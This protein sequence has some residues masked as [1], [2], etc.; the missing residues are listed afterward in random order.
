VV[1][2]IFH[3]RLPDFVLGLVIGLSM[4]LAWHWVA[5]TVVW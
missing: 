3:P 4:A 5:A 2:P 1:V